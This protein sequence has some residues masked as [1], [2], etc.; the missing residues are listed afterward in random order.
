MTFWKTGVVLLAL[1]LAGMAVVPVVSAEVQANNRDLGTTSIEHHKIS[2]DYLK[3]SKPA[4]WLPESEMITFVISQ[5]TVGKLDQNKN[6]ELINI[7]IEYL[8]SK[9]AQL[10]L[11]KLNLILNINKNIGLVNLNF[12]T[13]V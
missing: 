9:S 10:T 5:K 13:S 1:L 6:E 2:D 3:D 7:P 12:F 11:K 4:E 8:N